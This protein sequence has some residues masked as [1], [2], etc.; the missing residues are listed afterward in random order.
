MFYFGQTIIRYAYKN[1]TTNQTFK[2]KKKKKKTKAKKL[3]WP[4]P[5][6]LKAWNLFALIR[7]TIIV[8]LIQ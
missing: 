4:F 1:S 5:V 8:Q 3:L 6:L 7:F 2:F